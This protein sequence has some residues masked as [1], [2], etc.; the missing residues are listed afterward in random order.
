MIDKQSK[1]R[2]SKFFNIW[3]Y[4]FFAICMGYVWIEQINPLIGHKLQLI[5]MIP[6]SAIAL[7]LSHFII[8]SQIKKIYL[9]SNPV[10]WALPFLILAAINLPFIDIQQERS[11]KELIITWFWVIFLIPMMIRL[12]S[13]SSGRLHYLIFATIAMLGVCIEYYQVLLTFERNIDED[14]FISR[15]HLTY[16]GIGVFPI[17]I[18]YAF[19]KKGIIRY[20]LIVSIVF[21]LICIIPSGARSAW[22]VMPIQ[23]ILLFKFVLPVSRTIIIGSFLSVLLIIGVRFIEFDDLYTLDTLAH[24]ETRVRKFYEW[25]DDNTVW[26]RFGM[27]IK[28]KLILEEYPLLGVGYSN[29]SFTYFDGGDVLF[30]GRVAAVRQVDA[31]NTYINILGTTGI[32]G[33]LAFLF[34][35]KNIFRVIKKTDRFILKQIDIGSF[36]VGMI[37]VLLNMNF[38]TFG[39]NHFAIITAIIPAV[40]NYQETLRI[41]Y[42][43]QKIYSLK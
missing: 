40:Y 21:L 7:I 12:L 23:L 42:F 14:I 28:A 3:E 1:S 4:P 31:H 34:Y 17:M 18:G 41:N 13:T 19:L 25:Q 5:P 37:G 32:L 20:F 35:T 6:N 8:P 22:L 39:F 10:K 36:I 16:A 38:L 26:K 15:H 11:I 9:F 29:K 27:I 43:N 30:M 2:D 33:F 24:F